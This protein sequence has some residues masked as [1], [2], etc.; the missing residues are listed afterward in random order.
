METNNL[1]KRN[2]LRTGHAQLVMA[3]ER[4]GDAIN[5]DITLLCCAHLHALYSVPWR[6]VASPCAVGFVRAE[7]VM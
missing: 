4:F 6:L 7:I 3:G 1:G 2:R 5:G